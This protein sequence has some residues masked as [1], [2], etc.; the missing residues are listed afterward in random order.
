[1]QDLTRRTML[2]SLL[3]APIVR[4]AENDR[5][6]ISLFDGKTLNGWRSGK[7][8]SF[9]VVDGAI[10]TDGPTAHLFYSGPVKDASFK[11][12][13]F[14]VEVL[15]KAAANS[16]VYFHTAYQADGFPKEGFEVQVNNTA[17]GERG[18]LERKKTGSLYGVRNVYK[19]LVQDDQWFELRIVVRGKQVQTYVDGMLLVDYVEPEKPAGR[20]P[21]S[22]GTFAFQCHDPGS[23]AHFRNIAV[24]PLPDDLPAPAETPVVDELYRDIMK[25]GADN[26]P[27]VDY[28]VHLKG[29]FS[30]ED[31]MR[32]SR[33]V[34]IQYGIA[35]N[36]GLK[37]PIHDDAGVREFLATMKGKPVFVA[38]Q[39]EGREWVNLVSKET[40]AQFDYAFTDAMTFTD[41]RGKR[42]RLWIK[43]EVGEITDRQAFMETYVNRILGV[44]NNEPID[45]HV[46]PTFLPDVIAAGYDELW[47]P[48]RMQKV[49]DAAKKNNIAIEI[50]NRY[51]L[52]S[53]AFIKLAKAAGVKFSMGTNNSDA[54]IGRCE[55]A[56]AMIKECKLGWRDFFV[57]RKSLS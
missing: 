11:N 44:L 1:M 35:V 51:K 14:K 38:L 19:K 41:D 43:E 36:C 12:F 46:N 28:H 33:R 39:G 54:N 15:T 57:P 18:Y 55:Y 47:T 42:M 45:I 31:A 34:G 29:G 8:D 20:G 6:W 22:R 4:S 24:R 26:Y 3:A 49:I 52:P 13:E 32:E 2:A 23:K 17:T 30:L 40:L 53:P 7:L 16:G 27:M 50:N 37:F 48:E 10:V 9:K 25:L 5:D 21:V 56:I